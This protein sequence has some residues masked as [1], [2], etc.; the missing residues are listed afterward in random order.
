MAE[1]G[2]RVAVGCFG[3]GSN[4]S[5]NKEVARS[6]MQPLH[7]RGMEKI[8]VKAPPAILPSPLNS[9]ISLT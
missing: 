4:R 9:S 1:L 2:C 8:A 5:S 3:W 6:L 7:L